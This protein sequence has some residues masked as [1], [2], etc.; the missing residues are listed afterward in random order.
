MQKFA[1]QSKFSGSN[2]HKIP[3]EQ[4]VF[5]VE[6]SYMAVY[7]HNV[8][9]LHYLA[10]NN[11]SIVTKEL[12]QYAQDLAKQYPSDARAKVVNYLK[13]DLGWFKRLLP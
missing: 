1:I 8:D 2:M 10:N 7:L 9:L 3:E 11:K 6:T 13:K 4:K 12:Y 5:L